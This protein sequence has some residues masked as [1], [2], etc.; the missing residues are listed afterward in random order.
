MPIPGPCACA[1]EAESATLLDR[2]AA[3]TWPPMSW[4]RWPASPTPWV[5]SALASGLRNGLQPIRRR[6]DDADDVPLHLPACR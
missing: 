6:L 3:L 5:V 2:V 1:G 4:S